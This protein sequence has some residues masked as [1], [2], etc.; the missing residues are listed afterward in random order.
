MNRGVV[1]VAKHY[2]SV[3]IFVGLVC[4]SSAF[5]MVGIPITTPDAAGNRHM[6]I[7][8][9]I[10][11]PAAAAGA[12]RFANNWGPAGGTAPFS[13][14]AP[15][16]IKRFF[17]WNIPYL[18]Y[19]FD[20]SFINYFGFEGMEAVN[21]AFRIIND[22]FVPEDGSYNGVTQLDLARHGFSGN[23][24]TTWV[25]TTAQNA[26][27]LD[28][29][30]LVLGMMVNNLGLGNPHRHAFSMVGGTRDPWQNTYNFHVSLRN[31][32]PYS[33][34]ET[35]VINGVQYAY[36]L[37]HN[38]V[39]GPNP[40]IPNLPAN[41]IVDM[42]EYTADTSGNAWT[43]VAGILDAFYGETLIYWN[44]QPTLFNFGVFYDS[45]N[46]MGGQFQPRHA[47]T[48]DDAGGLKYLYS[49]N[50]YAYERMG[51][52]AA[53]N[54]NVRL[55]RSPKF[56]PTT[57]DE[58]RAINQNWSGVPTGLHFPNPQNSRSFWPRQFGAVGGNPPT[59]LGAAW[60]STLPVAG[61]PILVPTAANLPSGAVTPYEQLNN[62]N[63]ANAWFAGLGTPVLRGGI[64]RIQFYNQ[65]MDSL[66]GVTFIATNWSWEVPFV[67]Q[68][69]QHVGG[70]TNISPGAVSWVGQR[71]FKFY[72]M[73]VAR[74]IVAPDFIFTADTLPLSADGVPLAFSRSN[75]AGAAARNIIWDD[76]ANVNWATYMNTTVNQAHREGGYNEGGP[77]VINPMA[78]GL[79]SFTK[80]HENFE[81]IWSGES[82]VVGN[83]N[84]AYSLWGH[85]KGPGP[86][87]VVAFPRDATMWRLENM[88]VPDA[89]PPI[90]TLISDDGGLSAIERDTYTRTEETLSII[91]KEMA[92]VTAVEIMN[93]DLVVHTIMPVDPYIQ[94]NTQIDLPPG[95]LTEVAEG[96]DMEVRV[97]N[98]I[99]AS[100]KGP[101]K[102]RIETGRP[103]ITGTD[104]DGLVFDR[105]EAI[106]VKGYGFLSRTVGEARV[107]RMRIDGSTGAS[108]ED[109]GIRAGVASDGIP[110]MVSNIQT[111]SDRELIIPMNS[112]GPASDG[113]LRRIRLARRGPV[114]GLASNLDSVLSPATNPMIGD[115][116]TKPVIKSLAQNNATGQWENVVGVDAT[117]M[118]KRDRM[119]EINGSG[120]N[121]LS[122]IEIV[123]ESGES[124]ANPVFIQ[125]PN[126]A[127]TVEDG[128]ARVTLAA[129]AISYSD[130]DSNG[131]VKRSVRLYNAIGTSDMNA[132][133][134]FAVNIQPVATGVVGFSL[135]GFFNRDKLSGDDI[136]IIGAGLMG[137]G[138]VHIID[139]NGSSL[140]S[141]GS[142]RVIVPQNGVTVTDTRITIDTQLAQF[143]NG[144]IADT[145][146]N[147]VGRIFALVSARN[148]ATT[149]QSDRFSVGLPPD[150]LSVGGFLVSNSY[151]R[152]EDTMEINGTGLGM[153]TKVEIVDM[154]GN[155]ITGAT[156]ATLTTGVSSVNNSQIRISANAPGWASS[157]SVFDLVNAFGRR[158]KV[159]TPFGTVISG[160]ASGGAF[161]VSANATYVPAV[162]PT[163]TA[164][165]AGGGFDGVTGIYTRGN[166]NLVINGSNF[167]G[168]KQIFFQRPGSG[169]NYTV[170]IDPN[171]PP[172][173]F[174]FSAD[175]NQITVQSSWFNQLPQSAWVSPGG[176]GR[177]VTLKSAA[178]RNTTTP[179]ITTNP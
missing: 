164:T 77:G 98:T 148:N 156:E 31:F 10:D 37:I 21:E 165:F 162:G 41:T 78:N 178:D 114:G 159:T 121:T 3:F 160:S 174:S 147:D 60:R 110:Y 93:G 29:K 9:T 138:E 175:G 101:V 95:L 113:N 83:Q 67:Y 172:A 63:V 99:G 79:I 100:E 136:E 166:G 47:L 54:A 26:Q 32:D 139:S 117:G 15:R 111:L 5:V 91:G 69:G 137:V 129:N 62:A 13:A 105:S 157:G 151:A 161:S 58:M 18:A 140:S 61:I 64:D 23:Y 119:L 75:P 68:S 177:S 4:T 88:A 115:I 24:N 53:N 7:N 45:Q 76:L 135:P 34:K 46:A 84:S 173:G 56:L 146:R 120:L 141:S 2:I 168:V 154:L 16:P 74:D 132:S 52:G 19:S 176:A 144:V 104:A 96:V 40:G 125:L 27:I 1:L 30:S 109:A 131:S 38:Q 59:R 22:F 143:S 11:N 72:S 17:R 145:G 169:G 39:P 48:F 126:P 28:L 94:S 97:W 70:L 163:S 102:F 51:G 142:P 133:Q 20:T 107:D 150:N 134:L 124:F 35:D 130:A 158:I 106:T 179:Q 12:L 80:L 49:T 118:F 87:D 153:V 127:V 81:L 73:T 82:T 33:L 55:L 103:V 116:T 89:S 90:I 65:P 6:E 50:T 170:T 112:M 123:K 149:P 86:G 152:D 8:P 85:I 171:A 36:R 25:N 42:E 92:G 43:A 71:S 57:Q 14:G 108:I 128:G 44:N 167:R 122:V 155:V 66:L